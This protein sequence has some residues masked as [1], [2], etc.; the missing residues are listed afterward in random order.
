MKSDHASSTISVLTFNVWGLKIG[1]IKLA[2]RIQARIQA[3]VGSIRDLNPDVVALQ[4]VWCDTIAKYFFDHLG[5]RYYAYLPNKKRLKGRMGNG[6]MFLSKFPILE[7]KILEFSEYTRFDEYFSAKGALMIQ[8]E[9]GRGKVNIVNTHLG[10]GKRITHIHQRMYQTEE[11][12]HFMRSL[13]RQQPL[14]LAGDFNFN[15]DSMEYILL[16][17]WFRRYFDED[18]PDTYQAIHPSSSGHTFYLNRSYGQDPEIHNQE[19]RIDYIFSL[20][21]KEN[22]SSVALRSCDVVMD[23]PQAPLSDHCGV[24]AQWAISPKITVENIFHNPI[25]AK[26]EVKL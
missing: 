24:M 8:I 16:K 5:Y 17:Q 21:R 22:R 3:A 6:L 26:E 20:S 14:I 9:T 23:I 7:Q 15:P 18:L 1:R 12:Q 4:E 11:L 13:P 2:R 19:E 25:Y 10:A